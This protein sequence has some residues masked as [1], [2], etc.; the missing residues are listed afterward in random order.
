MKVYGN[1]KYTPALE[2]FC[3][4]RVRRRLLIAVSPLAIKKETDFLFVEPEAL[5]A[6]ICLYNMPVEFALR[7]GYQSLR[8]YRYD[9]FGLGKLISPIDAQGRVFLFQEDFPL[10]F[11]I[12]Q[13]EYVDYFI[14][15]GSVGMNFGPGTIL[16]NK[17][18]LLSDE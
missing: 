16:E 17:I 5:T 12:K 10:K 4:S 15:G 6:H 11:T 2:D 9:S 1:D 13:D 14:N 7:S 8:Q 3:V 18:Y